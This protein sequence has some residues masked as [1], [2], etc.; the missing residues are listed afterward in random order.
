MYRLAFLTKGGPH[1]CP[2]E[3]CPGWEGMRT[4]TRI[5][6]CNRHVQEIVV[7]LEEGNFP[8]LRCSQCDMLVPCMTLN[9][10]H[11]AT[12]TSKKGAERKRRQMEDAELQDITERA[13]EA[14]GKPLETVWTFKYLGRVM[15]AVDDDWPAVAEKLL[16]ARKSWGRLLRILSR[17]GMEKRVSGNFFKVV[18]QAVVLFGEETWVLTLRIDLALESFLHGAPLQIT[19]KQPRGGRGGQ[20]T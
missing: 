6:F 13:F 7:I 10:R 19:R 11:H 15:T 20:W 14:Y 4:A 17:E 3:G 5:H 12:A 18:V 9:G 8:H 1:R 2:V 16:K